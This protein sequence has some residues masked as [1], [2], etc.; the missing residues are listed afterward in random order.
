MPDVQKPE[1]QVHVMGDAA[2]IIRYDRAAVPL[3]IRQGSLSC[4]SHRR[5]LIHW[6]DDLEFI[7]VYEGRMRYA[8][9]ARDL[10]LGPE[11][12]L[13]VNSRQMHGGRA[14]DENDCRFLCVLV[15]PQLL[16]GSPVLYREQ[17]RP[18]VEQPG[19]ECLHFA[20]GET[21]ADL[22]R[23]RAM[24]QFIYRHYAEKL[25]LADIAA[26]G[27]VCRSKCCALFARYAQQPPIEY[28]NRYRLEV[29]CD[30]LRRGGASVT[31]V[32]LACGFSSPA[33][34]AQQFGR[35]YGCTPRAWRAACKP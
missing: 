16:T 29:S 22:A 15:R 26:A 9:N 19:L 30:M 12:V 10:L 17:V 35:R 34:F 14:A 2:E 27:G 24:V 28:L 4:Y 1:Y 13:V 6:H 5:A 8:V 23:Q 3:Y 18:F 31:E 33:Y 11:D 7:R 32:A 21:D 25:T 20:A